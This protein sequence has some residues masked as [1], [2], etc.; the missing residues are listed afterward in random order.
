MTSGWWKMN[1]WRSMG[2]SINGGTV[3]GKAK[4]HGSNQTATNISSKQTTTS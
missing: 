2:A 3:A 4:Q 1:V